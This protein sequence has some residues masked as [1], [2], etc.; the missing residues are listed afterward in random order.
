ME[1]MKE[2]AEKFGAIESVVIPRP[3]PVNLLIWINLYNNRKLE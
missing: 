2:E 1:D 3:D